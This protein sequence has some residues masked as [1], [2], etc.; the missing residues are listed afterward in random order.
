M[1]KFTFT[2]LALPEIIKIEYMHFEDD[3]GFF[4]EVYNKKEFAERGIL[5]NFVQDNISFSKKNV[6]RGIHF[7][8]APHEMSKLVRCVSGEIWDVAVDVRLGSPT[9]GKYVAETLSGDNNKILYIPKG[10]AHGFCVLSGEATVAYK[11]SDYYYPEIDAG[12][13]YN[14]PDIA[15]NWPVKE[16]IMSEKDKK[17]PNLKDLLK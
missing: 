3:R 11:Q 14:D 15:I 13:I 2:E 17:L 9:F 1:K 10:F 5:D 8:K 6:I 12:V 16:P 4:S 7:S